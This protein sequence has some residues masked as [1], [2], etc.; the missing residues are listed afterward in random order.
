MTDPIKMLDHGFV[1]LVVAFGAEPMR[2]HPE[3]CRRM[4]AAGGKSAN[5]RIPPPTAY[6]GPYPIPGPTCADWKP[7]K[8]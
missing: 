1:R 4:L 2:R 8:D 5:A 7:I 6:L 3:H